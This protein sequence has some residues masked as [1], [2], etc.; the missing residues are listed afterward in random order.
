MDQKNYWSPNDTRSVNVTLEDLH[1]LKASN[2]IHPLSMLRQIMKQ[3]VYVGFA[4][5]AVFLAL[6]ILFSQMLLTIVLIPICLY[7][8]YFLFRSLKILQNMNRLGDQPI[9]NILKSIKLQYL[10]IRKYVKSSETIAIF[11][12]PLTILAGMVITFLILGYSNPANLFNDPFLIYLLIAAVLFFVPVQYF[13]TR[14]M[15]NKTFGSHLEHLKGMI[16]D[17]ENEKQA[18]GL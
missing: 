9:E 12:Y 6:I 17:L 18:K 8:V 3:Q 5:L 7:L 1:K 2:S 10:V 15:N 4:L 11:L 14:K 16:A 13:F